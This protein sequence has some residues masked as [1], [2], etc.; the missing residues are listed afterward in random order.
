M[1]K[2][3]HNRGRMHGFAIL[4]DE[5]ARKSIVCEMMHPSHS[6]NMGQLNIQWFPGCTTKFIEQINGNTLNVNEQERLE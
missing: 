4:L 3:I 1:T 2:V 5:T 6:L